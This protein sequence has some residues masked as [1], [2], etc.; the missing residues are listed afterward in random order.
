MQDPIS[1]WLAA[2][3]Q[4][5]QAT[6]TA[7][8]NQEGARTRIA[9]LWIIFS[10]LIS[11]IISLI[12]KALLPYHPLNQLTNQPNGSVSAD[13]TAQMMESIGW[14]SSPWLWFFL[15]PLLFLG[16]VGA[17]HFIAVLLGGRGQFRPYSYLIA[18]IQAPLGLLMAV[19]NWVPFLGQCFTMLI[20]IGMYIYF[21]IATQAAHQIG[22]M[23]ALIA[24]LTPIIIITFFFI[25]IFSF[26][27]AAIM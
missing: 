9:L 10:S 1:I 18:A 19:M 17:N 23:K 7:I 11:V 26:A 12:G 20:G 14:V 25:C 8:Y 4:P 2:I 5:S 22:F 15:G 24:V 13:Q 21:A 16:M 3:T 27:L 6:Y